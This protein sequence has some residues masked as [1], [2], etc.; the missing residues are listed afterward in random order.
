MNQEDYQLVQK[1]LAQEQRAF[2]EFFDVYFPRLFRFCS[3]RINDRGAVEEIVQESLFKALRNL[4][5]YR[6][7]ATLFT[8]L[9]Q[10]CRNEISN[11]Y[12]RHGRKTEQL[13]S[14]DD[15]PEIRASLETLDSVDLEDQVALNRLV[16]LTLDY[17][18]D[19]YGRVLEWKYLEGLSVAEISKRSRQGVTA[20]QSLLSRARSAF[21][22]AFK[23]VQQDVKV[24]T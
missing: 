21:R 8:W 16:Q 12:Q 3:T 14:L 5:K 1:V 6:G 11:W 19:Q 24:I 9:C 22:Q 17:L 18:P 13:I 4:A 23:E 7:E 2:E 10:I 20:T 15:H